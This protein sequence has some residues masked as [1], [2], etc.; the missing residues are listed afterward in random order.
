MTE[1]EGRRVDTSLA[2]QSVG[3][4]RVPFWAR[5]VVRPNLVPSKTYLLHPGREE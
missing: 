5:T 3:S 1:G 2:K 4:Y